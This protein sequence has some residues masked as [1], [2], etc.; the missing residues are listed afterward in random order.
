MEAA[1]RTARAQPRMAHLDFEVTWAPFQLDETLPEAGE[2]KMARYSRRF[3]AQRMAG[4]IDM[5]KKTGL[6]LEP[7]VAFSYGGLVSNTISSHVVLEAALVE[8]GPALQD[9]VVERFFSHCASKRVAHERARA[10]PRPR[11]TRVSP[12]GTSERLCHSPPRRA[13]RSLPIRL[14]EG[15]QHRGPRRAAAHGRRRGHD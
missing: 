11:R 10:A 3:G 1:I 2:S 12:P 4:M 15:G 5:M 6:A 9:R 14:R 13:F 7:P 8:G